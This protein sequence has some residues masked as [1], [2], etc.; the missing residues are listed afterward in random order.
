MGYD[1]VR[2]IDSIFLQA[3][4]YAGLTLSSG[5]RVFSDVVGKLEEMK[6]SIDS[7]GDRCAEARKVLGELE[8]KVKA[9]VDGA[10]KNPVKAKLFK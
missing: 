4:I 5:D 1:A 2:I 6:R 10:S 7:A 3:G 8:G 9:A